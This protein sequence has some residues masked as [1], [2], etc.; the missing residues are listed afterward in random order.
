M[1]ELLFSNFTSSCYYNGNST[2]R[3][4]ARRT[5]KCS[6]NSS[7]AGDN[8]LVVSGR[9][10]WNVHCGWKYSLEESDYEFVFSLNV[11]M[12]FLL[13]KMS[14]FFSNENWHFHAS[15]VELDS[16]I[17]YKWMPDTECL[18]YR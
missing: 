9:D 15:R 4:I 18:E 7:D 16:Q 6:Q 14:M 5:L 10:D 3:E 13:C 11:F 1:Y 12:L 8:I 17:N 2:T